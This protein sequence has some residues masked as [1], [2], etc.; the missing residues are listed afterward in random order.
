MP[1]IA[2]PELIQGFTRVYTILIRSLLP[3][4]ASISSGEKLH[5]KPLRT[6]RIVAPF[7]IVRGTKHDDVP[8]ILSH[9]TDAELPPQSVAPENHV[10]RATEHRVDP[11]PRPSPRL[12]RTGSAKDPD[13]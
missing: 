5:A 12:L 4:T 9:R 6:L 7:Y 2:I 13:R 1:V 11:D 8:R 3:L 10:A